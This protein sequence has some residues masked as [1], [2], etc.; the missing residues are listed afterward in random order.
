MAWSI[1]FSTF[2]AIIA[3]EHTEK[4]RELLAYQA[5]I[6]IEAIRFGCKGWLSYGKLF[7]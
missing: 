6:L 2:V 4:F 7:R 1:S 5:T 3:K